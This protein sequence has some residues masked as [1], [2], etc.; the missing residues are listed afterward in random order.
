[1]FEE[2]FAMPFLI[3]WPGVVKPGT[4]S[5]ALIQNID[6]APTFLEAAGIEIPE[7]IDGRSLLPLFRNDG[8][9]ADDWRKVL[10]YFYS[11]PMSHNVAVHDGIA[12][13]RYKLFYL[14]QT[15]EW[16]LFDLDKDPHE[17][18]SLH[19]HAEY[20]GVLAKMKTLYQDARAHYG[21]SAE[22]ELRPSL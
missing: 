15:D 20:A 18:S 3:R 13:Q 4:R 17:M 12:T 22:S 7:Y 2:S 8:V 16:Q 10:Y 19:D 5:Q 6:H 11:D 1:M 9:A 21:P 14:P